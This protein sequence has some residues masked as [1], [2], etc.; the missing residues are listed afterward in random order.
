MNYKL[1]LVD[2]D[3]NL[4]NSFQRLLSKHLNVDVAGDGK[5]GLEKIRNEGPYAMVI[6]DYK[7]PGMNGVEFLAEVAKVEPDTVRILLTAY[8]NLDV[9]L[10][11][12]NKG[13][14]FR[15]L[16]KPCPKPVL[17]EVIKAGMRQYQLVKSEKELLEQTVT[18]SMKLLGELMNMLH[19]AAYE[20]I[21]RIQPLLRTVAKDLG[22]K[23]LWATESAAVLSQLG[24]VL[25]PEEVR[26]KAES[27]RDLKHKE[28]EMFNQYPETSGKLIAHIPRLE[29]VAQIALYVEKHYDGSGVPEDDVKGGSIPLGARIMKALLDYDRNLDELRERGSLKDEAKTGVVEK[30]Q[31]DRRYDPAVLESLLN[32]LEKEKPY[33]VRTVSPDELEVNMIL[34]EDLYIERK[35][36]KTKIMARGHEINHMGLEYMQNYAKFLN[37]K[38]KIKV[39]EIT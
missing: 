20:R 29:D 12:V 10:E 4:L 31:G 30:M 36:K 17:G 39:I 15:L 34:A 5:A 37:L 16:T 27:G 1:L 14:I 28:R 33:R 7:M 8:A 6:S 38:K 21:N 3:E 24:Y 25:L 22:D 11:A 32:A 18:G 13:H 26:R 9:A 35:G 19:S 23:S 2:D